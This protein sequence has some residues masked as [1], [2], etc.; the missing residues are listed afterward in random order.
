VV[1]REIPVWVILVTAFSIGLVFFLIM[2]LFM[3]GTS[4]KIIRVINSLV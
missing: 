3:N 1:T 4:D 2:T